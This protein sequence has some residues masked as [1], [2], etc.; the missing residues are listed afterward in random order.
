MWGFSFPAGQVLQSLIPTCVGNNLN[1]TE[2]HTELHGRDLLLV[3]VKYPEPGR[4]KTRLAADVG[5]ERATRIY[6]ILAERVVRA[7]CQ[8]PKVYRVAL[9]HDPPDRREAFA[10]WLGQ[11][12]VMVPQPSGDLGQRLT[13]AFEWAF[14]HGARRAAA[15]GTDSPGVDR[16]VVASAFSA[17]DRKEL[18][19]GPTEDGG[20]YLIGLRSPCPAIFEGIPWSGPDVLKATLASADHLG[21]TFHLLPV[22]PDIATGEDLKRYLDSKND[23]FQPLD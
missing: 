7:V 13:G 2:T 12:L 18:V 5:H 6:R 23:P 15:I 3:F 20:Y 17:L 4:V 10:A 22:L 1:T 9:C 19:L 14:T 8:E 11:S 16:R 21:L